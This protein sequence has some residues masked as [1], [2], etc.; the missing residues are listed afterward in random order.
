MHTDVYLGDK[1]GRNKEYEDRTGVSKHSAVHSGKRP[2]HYCLGSIACI[3]R[4][5][6]S[7]LTLL[8]NFYKHSVTIPKTEVSI[9]QAYSKS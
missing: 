3:Q 8:R 1:R 2:I 7:S 4:G 9:H 6:I 5:E